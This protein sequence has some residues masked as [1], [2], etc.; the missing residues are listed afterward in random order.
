ME[1]YSFS[2]NIIAANDF[3]PSNIIDKLYIDFLN[4]RNYFDISEWQDKEGNKK[5]EFYSPHCGGFDFW[6]T[7]KNVKDFENTTILHLKSW[8]LHQGLLAYIQDN[9]SNSVFDLL[10]RKLKF[11]IHVVSYNK[12]GYYNWHQDINPKNIFTM[13]LILQKPS[14][15]I[16]GEFLFKDNNKIIKTNNTHNFFSC[17]PSFI[18]HAVKPLQ[19]DKEVS[20]LDQ[21]FSIQFW[22]RLD[23]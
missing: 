1:Y 11:S 10:N 15:L 13:N 23:E 22:W 9:F 8:F 16:G 20:F 14:N 5:K 17:F 6:I 18:W 21:R 19:A 2:K 3:L 12:E 4:L 7:D